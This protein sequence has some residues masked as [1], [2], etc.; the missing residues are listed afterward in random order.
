MKDSISDDDNNNKNNELINQQAQPQ[1]Q[2]SSL[3]SQQART[4]E[5]ANQVTIH[6]TNFTNHATYY[7]L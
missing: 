1:E 6:Y 7:I 2:Q 4:I 5:R 3:S